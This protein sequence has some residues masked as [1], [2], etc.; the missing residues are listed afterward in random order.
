MPG[1][2]DTIPTKSDREC[3][4]G[5]RRGRE[6]ENLRPIVERYL[7]WVFSS[8]FRQTGSPE[9]A[10]EVT[11]AVFLVLARRSRK[12][13]KR[14][15]LA[16]WLFEL[17]RV[18][19]RNRT[20]LWRRFARWF[21]YKPRYVANPNDPLWTR[22]APVI[23][24]AVRLRRRQRNAVLLRGFLNYDATRAA[25]MLRSSEPR[26]EKRFRRGMRKLARRLRTRRAPVDSDALIAACATEASTMPVPDGLALGIL[27][28]VG[29]MQGG[30]PRL[31]IAR[32]TL[33]SLFWGRWRRRVAIGVPLIA[34]LLVLTGVT[35]WWLDRP[36]GYSR[37]LSTFIVWS[38]RLEAR[39]MDGSAR[40]W[41]GNPAALRLDGRMVRNAGDIYQRTNIWLTHLRFTREQWRALDAKYIGTMPN[42]LKPDGMPLLRNPNAQRA[43]INGVLGYEFDWSRGDFDFAGAGFSN[44]AVRVKGNLASLC[45]PKRSFKVDLN[46]IVKGQKLGGVDELVFNCL[47]WDYSCL[48][49]ALGYEFYRDAG[50]PAPR[51]AYAWLTATVEGRR[52]P[53]GLY[54]MVEQ[55]GDEFAKERFGSKKTPIFKPVTYDLFKHLG[56]T[57]SSYAAIYDLKTE[58]SEEQLR[59]VMEFAKLVS[60]ANDEKFAAEAGEFLDLDGFARFLASH[61]L[62]ASYDS[63]LTDGQNFYMYLHPRSNKFGFIPWDLDAAW[64]N[65]WI[66]SKRELE[67][68]SIW[69]P[70]VGK[71]RFIE[72][73][74]GL[75]EF[76]RLY[77]GHLEDLLAR[78]FVPEQLVRRIDE[79][80]AVIRE[81]VAA[82][83]EFRLGKFEQALG[84]DVP[85]DE[86]GMEGHRLKRFINAR[87]RSVRRQ[88][89][90]Q[91]KG[92][93]VKYRRG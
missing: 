10:A 74:M 57:W 51:T 79:M 60:S 46:K 33:R 2:G 86:A 9:E 49:E 45:A 89:D 85:S 55:V 4:E 56:D 8:A 3:L 52:K 6:A 23:D 13:G 1:A 59:R 5:W 72:R 12:V 16:A 80:A 32:R 48:Y 73:V 39:R 35:A 68:A 54:L 42:F 78:V 67:R 22:V 29:T 26:V 53:L 36:T 82:E 83:S 7:G 11:R 38:V 66:A 18:A 27:E 87:A 15:V 71:N 25:A 20:S 14:A 76:R 50:V 19:C 84:W 58:A 44:V 90:G 77:R 65:F 47:Y 30:R 70:W 91:S 41:A 69:H 17:T 43:G 64:G 21:R 88:L 40:P 75:E 24:R 34:L 81:P 63:I 93:I 92:M 62:L 28:D 31:K 37:L 61:V